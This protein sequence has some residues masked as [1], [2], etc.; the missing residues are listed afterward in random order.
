MHMT[1][2]PEISANNRTRKPVPVSDAS[3]SD[4]Q[5]GT[6]FFW[7]QFLVT[8]RT[9]P[10]IVPVYGT[11]FLVRVFSAHFWQSVMGIR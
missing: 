6:E 9:C 1:H 5:F 7:Y 11:S 3:D 4:M 10:I 2:V 8:N